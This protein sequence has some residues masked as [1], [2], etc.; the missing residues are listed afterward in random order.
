MLS[1]SRNRGIVTFTTQERF[2]SIRTPSSLPPNFKWVKS[3][4]GQSHY[5]RAWM[6]TSRV[7]AQSPMPG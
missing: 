4:T 5:I 2:T 7:P 1:Q 6:N 3:P